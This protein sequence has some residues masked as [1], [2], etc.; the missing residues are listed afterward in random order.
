MRPSGAAD[1][2]PDESPAARD[3]RRYTAEITGRAQALAQVMPPTWVFCHVTAAVLWGLP[4]PLRLLRPAVE[5]NRDQSIVPPRG[6]DV[7]IL[8]PGR[9]PRR[10]GIRGYELSPRLATVRTVKGMPVT[11]PATTWA[12]LAAQLTVDELV[13]LGDAIVFIPRRQG[14]KRGTPDDAL[15]T[16][17]HLA[18]AAHAPL[19][20]HAV[21]LRQALALVRVGSASAAETRVRLGCVRGGLPEP[22]LDFDVFALDG[23]AIGFT[24]FAHEEFRVLTEYEGD[25][26]RVDRAQWQRDVE[27][28]A[29]CVDAGWE[30]LRLTAADA[31][32]RVEPAV[33]RIRRAL[34]RGGW[35]PDPER[36]IGS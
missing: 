11:S 26:H 25:H 20:R 10:V 4:V 1:S 5:R 9:A 31:Y 24:E 15:G 14:M 2:S 27:K 21:K 7:G 19:R 8:A 17:A 16:V 35:R 36:R 3:A 13:A 12:M 22:T 33:E 23:T 32:P 6:L 28:H 18:S 34:I 29:A 30:V